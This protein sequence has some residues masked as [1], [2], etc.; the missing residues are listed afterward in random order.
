MF[1]VQFLKGHD[2]LAEFGDCPPEVLYKLFEIL[3][4]MQS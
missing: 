3:F 1:L 2:I 4:W